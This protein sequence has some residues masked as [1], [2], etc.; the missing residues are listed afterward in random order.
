MH[1]F[2]NHR[3][4]FPP[5]PPPASIARVDEP[6]DADGVK[7][8]QPLPDTS[9]RRD[10]WQG[11]LIAL[12]LFIGT[13]IICSV[14]NRYPYY[15]EKDAPSKVAQVL[16][17]ERNYYHP[18][19][20][21]N[22][23]DAVMRV[24]GTPRTPQDTVIVGRWIMVTCSALAAAAFSLL[25][26]RLAGTAG[27][28]CG[29]LFVATHPLV[30]ELSHH[31]KEDP[32]L[33][34]GLAFSFLA[35]Q[36][37]WEAPSRK[38]AAL[39]GAAC[40]IAVSA[41]YVG[42]AALILSLAPLL[43][44]KIREGGPSRR[45]CLLVFAAG[46]VL[47]AA[48]LNYQIVANVG[49]F[50]AGFG[51]EMGRMT[52]PEKVQDLP[53]TDK[54]LRTHRMLLG[55]PFLLF[56]ALQL[57]WMFAAG[58]RNLIP[59]MCLVYGIAFTGVLLFTPRLYTR[60][61]LPITAVCMFL[62]GLGMANTARL[63][64]DRLRG[65]SVQKHTV[66]VA[67]VLAVCVYMRW[68]HHPL[69]STSMPYRHPT[70]ERLIHWI[71]ENLPPTAVI[72][73]DDKVFLVDPDGKPRADISLPQRVI[74]RRRLSEFGTLE[75][76]ARLG[77]THIAVHPLF[78]PELFGRSRLRD[79]KA[80]SSNDDDPGLPVRRKANEQME[81]IISGIK[82]RKEFRSGK[83]GYVAPALRL[84]AIDK[85]ILERELKESAMT[86]TS[87]PETQ[88]DDPDDVA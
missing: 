6:P 63:L 66:M 47:T 18:M 15:Y 5:S 46:F 73:S 10:L 58:R 87:S 40:A 45:S 8:E 21:L 30:F 41:K 62:A 26:F 29:G 86:E 20:M 53:Q 48:V 76:M 35:M 50:Q 27:A 9:A 23:T 80:L 31:F 77:V 51:S 43:M 82:L 85:E 64:C 14:G 78:S 17:G 33:L 65:F 68:V 55:E 13:M 79:T 72:A 83:N 74:T 70:R 88:A 81:A 24:I 71:A 37:W 59:W 39:L 38:R 57:V 22:A 2:Q 56:A 42:V 28:I 54:V 36:L 67:F 1:I 3:I 69:R 61:F 34:A 4:T 75:E 25:G 16:S 7:S 44:A 19:L 52:R 12:V 11:V 60:H 32:V 49:D 84:F